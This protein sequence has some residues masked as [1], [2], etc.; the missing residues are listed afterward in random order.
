[1][2]NPLLGAVD[3]ALAAS[4]V[5]E[6]QTLGGLVSHCYVD[7]KIIKDPGAINDDGSPSSGED[8]GY[9]TA[10]SAGAL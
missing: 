3:A 2:L 7:A 5:T 1:M 4:K 9:R 8:S 6:R 10:M